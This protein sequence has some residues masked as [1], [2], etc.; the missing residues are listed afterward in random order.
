MASISKNT[1]NTIILV[2]DALALC[3]R[4]GISRFLGFFDESQGAAAR[5][6]CA[7]SG[8]ETLFYGGHD[9]AERTMLGIFPDGVNSAYEAFPITALGFSYRDSCALTHRDF[10]GTILS[11][12]VE[13]DVVGDILCGKGITVAFVERGMA[14]FIS[15]QITR[16]GGEGVTVVENYDGVLPGERRTEPMRCTVASMRLDCIVAAAAGMSRESASSAIKCGR[17]SLNHRECQSIS[18]TVASN[19][20]LSIRGIGRFSIAGTGTLTRKGRLAVVVEKY[21]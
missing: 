19:D 7:R 1:D 5:Q 21:I 14:G 8:V 10:L 13:R 20:I 16:V 4:R 18:H 2:R 6:A 12:G 3:E 11:C 15:S 9:R 17:V